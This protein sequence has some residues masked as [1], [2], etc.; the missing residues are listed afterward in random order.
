MT[1]SN[2]TLHVALAGLM[3][4][5]RIEA[6]LA[7][8]VPAGI[9]FK[10]DD[11]ARRVVQWASSLSGGASPSTASSLSLVVP[12]LS[13]VELRSP[14]P[15]GAWH[16]R[17]APLQID[18]TVTY[19]TTEDSPAQ[20]VLPNLRR[21]LSEWKSQ[22]GWEAQSAEAYF[23]TLLAFLRKHLWCVAAS[24]RQRDV[25]LFHHLALTSAIAAC[26]ARGVD[27]DKARSNPRQPLA[28]MVRGD[29]SGIQNFIY[30]VTRP[31]AETEHVAKRLRGRSFYLSLLVEVAVDWLL[32]ELNLPPNCALFVGGGRFD[33]LVPL[34]AQEQ[35]NA[36]KRSL[37]GWL[38]KEFQGELGLQIATC[39][40]SAEDF[41]D[42]RQVYQT[43][44]TRL[45]TSK[46]QK[47]LDHINDRQFLE[48]Q[49]Q[50][51]HVCRICQLTPLSD[52]GTCPQCAQ[53]A[54]IGQHLPHATHLVYCYEQTPQVPPEQVIN[55]RN[56][57][58]GVQVVIVRENRDLLACL[59]AH[60]AKQVYQLN[61]TA[62]F[63]HAGT[64][65]SYRFL[66]NAAPRALEKIR[67]AGG[68][69]I[70]RDD[71]L[72][73]EG[74]AELSEGVKQIGILKADVDYMG[75]TMSEGLYE[76][77]PDGARPTIGRVAALSGALELFFAGHLNRICQAMFD[78][79]RAN[80]PA[81]DRN[82]LADK[83]AGLFYVMY[84]GGDDLF[85]VGPWDQIL[86]LAQRLHDEFAAYCGNNPNLT[87]SAGVVQVKPRYPTQ[88][89]AEL[90]DEAEKA[91]KGAGRNRVT[92]Y[93][94]TVSWSESPTFAELLAIAE[95]LKQG[96]QSN[97][98]NRG[99]IID[100]GQ[101]HRQHQE[102]QTG[103]LRPMWT[104][105]LYY[106]LARRLSR[107]A[108]KEYGKELIT[109]MSSGKV[110]IPVSVVGLLTRK[111]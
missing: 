24:D 86:K 26:L 51:W 53:H 57:P 90:A 36:L 64:P 5:P 92:A 78:E 29:L 8:F 109:T 14:A 33:L 22:N 34:D 21:E 17:I 82:P 80:Q 40:V 70:D 71:V 62:A 11:S 73:F 18:D 103:K 31:E 37:E 88:K 77:K 47:W 102:H 45:E 93:G 35:L 68:E 27:I 59:A 43:L 44:S 66:A 10:P 63:A 106:T 25:S 38:L 75:L 76:E 91:A 20:D 30:R 60:G 56:S 84:S 9:Q 16:H 69:S 48:P 32:R 94:Q 99:L 110:L 50:L 65:C 97:Q 13:K 23:T 7:A 107:E 41:S 55:F 42:M 104:P 12:I 2:S 85:I 111:E 67:F 95:H 105:R 100:L 58:F 3:S 54:H 72:H 79:W 15:A 46:Q 89:F 52:P 1:E 101:I 6:A 49:Q 81:A 61:R 74:I 28:L 98:I 96:I 87:L 39:E 108:R 4:D 83:V 19:P